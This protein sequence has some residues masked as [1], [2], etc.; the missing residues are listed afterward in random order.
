MVFYEPGRRITRNSVVLLWSHYDGVA[1]YLQGPPG[2]VRIMWW[3]RPR[4]KCDYLSARFVL[5]FIATRATTAMAD[6]EG[7]QRRCDDSGN[8]SAT[9]IWTTALCT[10]LLIFAVVAVYFV[11]CK[12]REHDW[13]SLWWKNNPGT[14]FY[15]LL[16]PSCRRVARITQTRSR[17]LSGP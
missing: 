16:F 13:S 10:A 6:D 3:P 15:Q 1:F 17:L 11:Y 14:R 5:L 2:R 7:E 12:R 9:V 8:A 4:W